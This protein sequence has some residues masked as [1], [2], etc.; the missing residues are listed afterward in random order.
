MLN[1]QFPYKNNQIILSSDRVILHAKDDGIFLFGKQMI[2]LASNGTV[3][4]DAKEAIKL[5]SDRIELGTAAYLKGEPVVLG[6]KVKTLLY[7]LLNTLEQV[8]IDLKRVSKSG[9][10]SSWLIIK[11]AGHDIENICS[12]LKFEIEDPSGAGYI[13]SNTTFTR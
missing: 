1:P 13:L 5:D 2:A 9:N 12:A 7:R 10:T 4:I 3:N 6:M 8:G 11:G